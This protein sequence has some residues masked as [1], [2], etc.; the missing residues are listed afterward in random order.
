MFGNR[1]ND[2]SVTEQALVYMEEKYGEVFTFAAPWG[3]STRG[4]RE[5]LV[6]CESIPGQRILVQVENFREEDKIF[7]DNYLA[8]KYREQT[9]EFFRS[10]A[11]DFYTDVNIHYDVRPDGQS[12]ELSAQ[13]SFEEVMADSR[14]DLVVLMELRAGEFTGPEHLEEIAARIG[15]LCRKVSLSV[16]VVE[17]GVFGTLDRAGLNRCISRREFVQR[18]VVYIHGDNVT[19]DWV[20]EGI[21]NE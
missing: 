18:G 12:G 8:V 1:L 10:C 11:G 17:D 4:T 15:K 14:T 5:I 19:I 2:P 20:S 21:G 13:A 16:I 3:D 7:R 9:V 6:T